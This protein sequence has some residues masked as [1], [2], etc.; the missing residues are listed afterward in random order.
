ML[1]AA[2]K[3]I[4]AFQLKSGG[5]IVS[6]N[7]IVMWYHAAVRRPCSP[8]GAA[9]GLT[10]LSVLLFASVFAAILFYSLLFCVDCLYS[11]STVIVGAVVLNIIIKYVFSGQGMAGGA[12]RLAENDGAGA[13]CASRPSR[14]AAPVLRVR[15][16]ACA[17]AVQPA[18]IFPACVCACVR[19]NAIIK[20]SLTE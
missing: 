6:H 7:I 11:I 19:Y 20:N 2:F 18:F 9:A 3:I 4:F 12:D 13:V 1:R 8:A 10:L 14:C 17:E 15:C 5:Y 16:F